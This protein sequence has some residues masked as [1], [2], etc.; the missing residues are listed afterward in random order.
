MRPGTAIDLNGNETTDPNR[1]AALVPFGAHKGYGLS[2]VNELI[3]A[4]IGGSLP[5]FRS[6]WGQG[7]DEKHTPSF[8]FQVIHP[9]A[10]SGGA[11]AKGRTQQENVKE[12]L[13][14]I[15]GGDNENCRLPGQNAA[16]IA[17]R[18]E[19]AGGLLFSEA[20]LEAFGKIA[21]EC[22]VAGWSNPCFSAAVIENEKEDA[23]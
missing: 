19:R 6:R 11:F 16:E 18:S 4:L 7:E 9:E 21:D 13:L 8:F 5:T 10:L 14:N 17:Q 23:R 1:V 3:A 20:E 22:G 12:V 15:L 2:L